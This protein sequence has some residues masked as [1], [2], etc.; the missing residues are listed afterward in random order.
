MKGRLKMSAAD[1]LKSSISS[2][3]ILNSRCAFIAFVLFYCFSP[4]AE[5]KKDG[6]AVPT[7]VPAP[8]LLENKGYDIFGCK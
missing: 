8:R 7:G 3:V 6:Y 4:T 1:Y 5:M 2:K